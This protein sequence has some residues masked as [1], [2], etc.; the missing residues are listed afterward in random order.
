MDRIIHYC[1]FGKGEK[2]EKVTGCIESWKKVFSDCEIR[3]WNESNF[4]INSVDFVKRAYEQRRWAFVSDYC[5]LFALYKYGGIYLDTDVTAVK[6]FGNIL[7]TDFIGYESAGRLCTAV[8]GFEKNSPIIKQ[9]MENYVA[10][11]YDYSTPTSK[12]F[13]DY[14]RDNYG[15]PEL[16]DEPVKAGGVTVYPA[17]YFSPKTSKAGV[18]DETVCVHECS[19]GWKKGRIGFWERLKKLFKR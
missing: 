1:W 16:S 12:H 5:R 17:Q 7:E 15:I 9:F 3:E 18:T 4:D 11:R 14:M 8:M 6:P 19:G 13:Y 2:S 10:G